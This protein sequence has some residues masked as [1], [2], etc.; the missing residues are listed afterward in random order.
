V[1]DSLDKVREE[2][3]TAFSLGRQKLS[4]ATLLLLV[5]GLSFLVYANT[6]SFEF[7]YDDW[8]QITRNPQLESW[9][10][11][12]GFFLGDV[13]GFAEHIT[14]GSYY[15]PVFT[16]WLFLNYKAFGT[17]PHWWHLITV[18]LHVLA[19]YL[20]Y[21]LGRRL[22]KS[23]GAGLI[24]A[25]FF[26]LTPLHIESVA[27]I[28]DGIDTMMGIFFIGSFLLFL[29]AREQERLISAGSLVLYG[30]AL[31]V[32]ETAGVL[33]AIV[34]AYEWAGM[35]VREPKSSWLAS[36]KRGILAALP[37]GGVTV[38]YAVARRMALHAMAAPQQDQPVG[39][40][41]KTLPAVL[42]FD[43][44][45]LLW[46]FRTSEFY[47]VEFVRSANFGNF[48]LPLIAVVVVLGALYFVA[49]RSRL[50]HF[51][52]W[53]MALPLIPA[54]V[55]L[56]M[57]DERDLVHDRQ[58][59]LSSI[60]FYIVVAAAVQC[61]ENKKLFVAVTAVIACAFGITTTWQNR[62]WADDFSLY[63]RA[64]EVAPR[65][66]L[67]RNHLAYV[68]MQKGDYK[69]ALEIYHQALALDP[70]SWRTTMNL[71]SAYFQTGELQEAEK[72]Y[73][74]AI[75][76]YPKNANQRNSSQYYYLGQ[77]RL[78]MGHF[79]EAEQP[80]RTAV[81]INPS[82]FGYHFGLGY[83]LLQEGKLKE[84]REQF[85]ADLAVNPQSPAQAD[86]ALIDARLKSRP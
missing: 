60:A 62:Y 83:V 57:Y 52:A 75:E 46:P 40:I 11:I 41:L 6:T 69:T 68:Y 10:N 73:E 38:V 23:E 19:T 59:Y 31:L 67:P 76:V 78:R 55:G 22:L 53:W 14:A 34:F 39:M 42:W 30:L 16:L 4:Y 74:R 71:G 43:I 47:G 7:V 36:A 15:R 54:L 25:L 70:Q 27:W 79:A 82:G 21:L 9:K 50:V 1:P 49:Q 66:P 17:N 44:Q 2:N 81:E 86:V 28:T 35:G 63:T 51:A 3:S 45:H 65:N 64:I 61:I 58:L 24:A 12:P 29:R 13:W 18:L 32:K 72:F 56:A 84:A 26:G 80:L 37:F 20:V 5:L 85:E 33:P 8:L 77:A 48:V